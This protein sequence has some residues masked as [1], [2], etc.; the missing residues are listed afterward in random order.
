MYFL[1]KIIS[2]LQGSALNVS[3]STK[4][5]III[6]SIWCYTIKLVQ[7]P[8]LY[9]NIMMIL[10]VGKIFSQYQRKIPCC[11]G[12]AYKWEKTW[13]FSHLLVRQRHKPIFVYYGEKKKCLVIWRNPILKP[14]VQPYI[15]IVNDVLQWKTG[16]TISLTRYVYTKS[17]SSVLNLSL[18]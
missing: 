9:S 17:H 12:F 2:V 6:W 15:D 4:C 5:I 1:S 10:T 11:Q 16:Q 8:V 14:K 18:A 7:S 3:F 13:I